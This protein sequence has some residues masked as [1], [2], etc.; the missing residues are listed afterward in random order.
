[1]ADEAGIMDI[2]DTPDVAV[3]AKGIKKNA[4]A[5]S[6]RVKEPSKIASMTLHRTTKDGEIMV[7]PANKK[8]VAKA[9]AEHSSM[10]DESGYGK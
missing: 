5:P 6:D 10:T 9:I 1:M 7:D 8:E 2:T 4:G 3:W